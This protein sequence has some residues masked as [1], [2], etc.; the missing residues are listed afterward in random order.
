MPLTR[1][2]S[3]HIFPQA[4]FETALPHF[5]TNFIRGGVC[6]KMLIVL[7]ERLTC[8]QI[9]YLKLILSF[10]LSPEWVLS[11]LLTQPPPTALL[12]LVSIAAEALVQSA[13]EICPQPGGLLMPEGQHSAT[14]ESRE[15]FPYP[16][17]TFICKCK[18]LDPIVQW[19][20]PCLCLGPGSTIKVLALP[21]RSL[22]H[23]QSP[24]WLSP[25]PSWTFTLLSTSNRGLEQ[26]LSKELPL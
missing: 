15:P 17:L 19:Y 5:L 12:W 4:A 9:Q 8:S 10:L 16:S 22:L 21:A 1:P 24:S 18:L 3:L 25:F 11:H 14:D 7:R 2:L 26:T 23:N 13:Q 20:E 6:F